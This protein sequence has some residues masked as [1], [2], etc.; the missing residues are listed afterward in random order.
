MRPWLQQGRLWPDG[1]AVRWRVADGALREIAGEGG[2]PGRLPWIAPLLFDAQVNGYAGVDFR[3]DGLRP[4]DLE[5]AADAFAADG[6]GRFLL[7]LISDDWDRLLERL[8]RYR[9]WRAESPLLQ[10]RIAGWHVEGPFLSAAPGY[11]G[12][13][14]PAVLRDPRPEDVRRLRA[15]CGDDLLWLT[16]APE[17]HG[18]LE[19]VAEARALGMAV[20]CGHTDA[21]AARL[22][23]ALAAGV[24]GFTHL[25][26]GCPAQ[27]DRADNI[28]WRALDLPEIRA[29]LIPDGLHVSPPLFRL[30]HRQIGRER[31]AYVTDAM[32][33]AGAPPGRYR[34]GALETEVGADG[35]V[36]LPG[37]R[38]FAGSSLRPLV[39]VFR[40]A[41]MLGRGWAEVWDGFS[42]RP[43][44]WAG[45][46]WGWREGQPADFCLIE[47][48]ETGSMAVTPYTEGRPRRR[49]IVGRSEDP[50]GLPAV[51]R[52]MDEG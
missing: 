40:A 14:V 7:T 32:S 6:G 20:W 21:P 25:G 10:R 5:R 37:T 46:P 26:N 27:L 23:A 16:L 9:A 38:Q 3:S 13:H 52:G 47:E 22:R 8:G 28:L 33:A 48:L 11:R 50:D 4:D 2:A 41:A 42:R 17:R 45:L 34:L 15:V 51:E 35:I 19:T 29:T 18:A 30:I 49:W 24:C 39:G 44:A 43:A 31:I 12:A 36:R 1:R